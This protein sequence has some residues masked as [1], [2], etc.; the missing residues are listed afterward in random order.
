[1]GGFIFAVAAMLIF[2]GALLSDLASLV[3]FFHRGRVE[4]RCD[5]EEVVGPSNDR[6]EKCGDSRS[7]GERFR[8]DNGKDDEE[9]SKDAQDLGVTNASEA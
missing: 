9:A 5:T 8:Q 1:M 2:G 4:N 7:G 3:C 6:E